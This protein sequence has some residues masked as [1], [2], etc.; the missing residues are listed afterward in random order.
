MSEE[1][2]YD[3]LILGGAHDQQVFNGPRK[4]ILEVPVRGHRVMAK[5][6]A[7]NVPAETAVH[8]VIAYKVIEHI[9][10]DGKHFYIASNEDLTNADVEDAILKFRISPIN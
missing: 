1:K 4:G 8:E 9:R 10:E 7:P 3:Y 5:M 2:F 6:Y